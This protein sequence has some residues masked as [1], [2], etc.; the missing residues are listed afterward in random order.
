MLGT[1]TRRVG[2]NWISSRHLRWRRSA[3]PGSIPLPLCSI[4]VK[5]VPLETCKTDEGGKAVHEECYVLK[6]K[7]SA[8][9]V[10]RIWREE[11]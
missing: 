8:T 11:T 1:L 6:L 5:P 9:P 10:Q 4:C 7:Q 3:V 2:L